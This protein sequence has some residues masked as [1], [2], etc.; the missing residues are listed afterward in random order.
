MFLSE[1]RFKTSYPTCEEGTEGTTYQRLTDAVGSGGR[2]SKPFP[3]SLEVRTVDEIQFY[4]EDAGTGL[5]LSLKKQKYAASSLTPLVIWAETSD[6]KLTKEVSFY[7]I[8][9]HMLVL[10]K[11]VW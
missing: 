1:Y 8:S 7:Y 11:K 4:K 3:A 9:N 10:E 2:W 5:V 6:Y